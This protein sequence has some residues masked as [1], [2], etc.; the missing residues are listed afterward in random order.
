MD[1]ITRR[2][3]AEKVDSWL[4]KS[5]IIVVVGQRRVGKSYVL[6]DFILRHGSDPVANIIY[7]DKEKR[8]FGF[9]TN[10]DQLGDY[11]EEHFDSSRHNYI[12]VDEIQDIEGW[13]QPIRSFRT[14]ENTDIIITGSNSKMLSSELSTLLGGRYQEI[15]VQSLSYLE[16]LEFHGLPDNDDT[17]QAYL[18][19]GG[20]PGLRMVGLESEEHVWEYLQGVFN[21]VM[22]KDVI[23][24]HKI[25]NIPFLNNLITFLSDTTGKINSATSISKFMKSQNLDVSANVILDYTRY[26]TEAYLVNEVRR[27]DIHG[28][29]LFETNQKV[30]FGDVGLRNLIAGGEREADIEKVIENVVYQHLIRLGYQVFVGELRVG[31]I[32]FV[33]KKPNQTKYVQTAYIIDNEETRDREFGRLADIKDNYPKYVISMTPLVKSRDYDGITHLGLREFLKNGLS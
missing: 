10:G 6:K 23:E 8:K 20:L 19:Y 17:L 28:K 29:K 11:I 26:Y 4:G 1:I 3:Y 31:E 24:R 14:E 15:Y 7:I 9:L 30:Y 16:F 33:C 5:H 22:L 25:R 13:E 12:L 18:N 32:D 27:Y 2:Q 21:T